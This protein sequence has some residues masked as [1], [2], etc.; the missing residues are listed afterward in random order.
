MSNLKTTFLQAQEALRDLV[1]IAETEVRLAEIIK[2]QA[3]ELEERNSEMQ[4]LLARI[5]ASSVT[6]PICGIKYGHLHDCRLAEL[7]RWKGN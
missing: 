3:Q 2:V 1:E 5:E 6:C 7:T 4:S